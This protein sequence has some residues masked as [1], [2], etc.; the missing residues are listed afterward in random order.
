MGEVAVKKT[1]KTADSLHRHYASVPRR[2][3]GTPHISLEA[4]V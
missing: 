4:L 1:E 2:I 3:A